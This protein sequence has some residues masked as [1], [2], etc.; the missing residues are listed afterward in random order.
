MQKNYLLSLV[1]LLLSTGVAFS[2]VTFSDDFE[3]YTVGQT[4]GVTSPVWAT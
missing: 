4:I 3:S 1:A 2:Q